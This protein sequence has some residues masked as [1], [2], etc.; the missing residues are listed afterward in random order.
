MTI[1]K[2]GRWGLLVRANLRH[3]GLPHL[4][5][6][7]ALLAFCPV[8]FG[9]ESLTAQA[10]WVPLELFAA[11]TGILLLT[12]LFLPEQNAPPVLEAVASRPTHLLSV[13]ALRLAYSLV[14]LTLL[15][16]VFCLLLR[17]GGCDVTP[18]HYGGTLAEALFLGALGTAASAVSGNGTVSYMLPML[19]YAMNYAGGESLGAFDLFAGMHGH[20]ATKVWLALGGMTLLGVGLLVQWRSV[21]RR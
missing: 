15:L 16:G 6:A 1:S 18:A 12:P 20:A 2:D 13:Y 5:L 14:F 19:Y 8:L 10:V 9:L 11:L 7:A 4:L 3:N 21:Y 17:G